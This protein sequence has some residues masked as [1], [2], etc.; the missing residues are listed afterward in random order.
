M[1]ASIFIEMAIS[2]EMLTFHAFQTEMCEKILLKQGE[3]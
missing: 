2:R 3:V 1:C